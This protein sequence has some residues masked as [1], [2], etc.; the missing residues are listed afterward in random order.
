[1]RPLWFMNAVPAAHDATVSKQSFADK[2][3]PKLELGNE[4]IGHEVKSLLRP[5]GERSF[6]VLSDP[7][8]RCDGE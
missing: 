5:S 8:L 2:R 7:L 1:M 6:Q 3:V 4:A